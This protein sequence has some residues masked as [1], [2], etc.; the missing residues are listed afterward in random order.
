MQACH[1][2]ASD[3]CSRYVDLTSERFLLSVLKAAIGEHEQMGNLVITIDKL[4]YLIHRGAIYEKLYPP[5]ISSTD[6]D[7]NLHGAMIGLYATILRSIALCH[8]LFTRS[9]TKRAMHALFNPGHVS[10][11]LKECDKLEQRVEY[12]AHNCERT[13]SQEADAEAKKLL[14]MLEEP[15]L[16]T[17]ERVFK[18]LERTEERDRLDILDW[19]SKVLYGSNHQRVTDSRATGTCE[20]LVTHKSYQEWQSE[21]ASI[22]LWLYG[23][24]KFE[25]F[26][27]VEECSLTIIFGKLEQARRFSRPK[28]LITSVVNFKVDLTK[29]ASHSSIAIEMRPNAESHCQC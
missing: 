23:N 20:W 19:V 24:R 9:T 22:I 27:F 5:E 7:D 26:T 25:R 10:E 8:R 12:E 2:Q 16:R 28:S 11:I 14:G 21:S 4:S 15:V 6:V 1:G 17:D 29:K 13:R 3:F 18:L